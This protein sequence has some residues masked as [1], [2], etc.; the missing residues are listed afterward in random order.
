MITD[1]ENKGLLK[2]G[3][4]IVECTAGNTGLGLALAA[5]LRKVTN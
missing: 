4:V 2:K 1:A 3:G 5:K